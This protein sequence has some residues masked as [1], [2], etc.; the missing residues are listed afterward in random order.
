MY[1][2]TTNLAYHG[3]DAAK[4]HARELSEQAEI[5]APKASAFDMLLARAKASAAARRRN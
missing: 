5:A 1:L 4:A 3:G 2:R